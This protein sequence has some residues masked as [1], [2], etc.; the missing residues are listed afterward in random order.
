VLNTDLVV[1]VSDRASDAL[2]LLF[3][4]EVGRGYLA[5]RRRLDPALVA[6]LDGLGLSGIANVL[7]AIKTA[8][9]LG[10]GAEDA[11][12]TVGTDSAAMYG[13]E[14]EKF[15]ASRYP[16]GFDQVNAGEVFGEHLAGIAD[17]HAVELDTQGRQRIFNLGY[18][19][20]VEQ[21]GVPL[22]EFDRRR[23]PRFWRKL[24]DAVPVW[25]RMIEEFNARTG[26]NR[27]G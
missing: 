17:D 26:L 5:Q 7:A 8:R 12:V 15:A 24:Q 18:Y 16:G 13:S 14:R 19:T 11:I 2:N 6:A 4:S 20:W 22:A 9:R 10:L 25:D 1:G 3:N 27:S 21:Q 23:D